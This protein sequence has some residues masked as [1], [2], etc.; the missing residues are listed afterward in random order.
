MKRLGWILVL[1]LLLPA[2]A[3]AR[4][5]QPGPHL[6]LDRALPDGLATEPAPAEF[7]RTLEVLHVRRQMMSAHQV[8]AWTAFSTIIASE[9]VGLVNRFSL[10]AG[11]PIKRADLEPS[12][13][14][15]RGLAGTA[16]GS[17]YGAGILAW[18]MPSP[19]TRLADKG[20]SQ[21]KSTRDTHIIL[22]ILHNVFMGMVTVTGILQ[23]N[24]LPAEAWEPVVS[25][26]T[27]SGF[28]TA[29][30]VAAA[31]IVIGKL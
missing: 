3:S 8:L 9:V 17:Y 22:S 28:A 21:W 13:A 30:F 15:H 25:L 14:L 2:S 18:S 12:L 1:A 6:E 27:V 20:I 19:S 31:S 4:E 11:G 23:A 10:Q 16:I 26:H 24:V 29:G 7:K 5:L